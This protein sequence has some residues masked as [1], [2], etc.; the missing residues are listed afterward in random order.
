MGFYVETVSVDVT[1]P[2]AKLPEA[3]QVLKDLDKPENN[4]LKGGGSWSGGVQTGWHYSWMNGDWAETAKSCSEI[5][6]K[7][8]FT[9]TYENENGLELGYY[10]SKTGNEDV[11]LNAVA[12][13]VDAGSYVEWRG[14]DGSVWKNVFDGQKMKTLSGRIVY[15]DGS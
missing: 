3:L 5:F 1:I 8:G 4:H 2:A 6:Q 7:L 11:F 10:D 13:F 15:G 12:P 14:E 9:D